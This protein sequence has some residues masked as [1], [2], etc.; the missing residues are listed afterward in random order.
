MQIEADDGLVGWGIF[1]VLVVVLAALV[2]IYHLL[3]PAV[4][5]AEALT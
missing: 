1:A 2:A 4:C 5:V 3:A